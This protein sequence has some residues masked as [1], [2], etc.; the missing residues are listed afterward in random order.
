MHSSGSGDVRR[1]GGRLL[2]GATG[3][4]S[5]GPCRGWLVPG[6]H[7]GGLHSTAALVQLRLSAIATTDFW[8]RSLSPRANAL[9]SHS[10]SATPLRTT[11]SRR[12]S[13]E[14]RSS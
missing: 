1:R 14:P 3:V 5:V 4:V 11:D 7:Y 9:L 13:L 10:A 8:T 12:P 6:D 2:L